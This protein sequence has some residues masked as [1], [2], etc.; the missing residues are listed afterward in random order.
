MKNKVK[1]NLSFS[2]NFSDPFSVQET[3]KK[4]GK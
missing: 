4:K 3:N 1:N 2:W